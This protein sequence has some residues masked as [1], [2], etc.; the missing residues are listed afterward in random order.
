MAAQNED[1]DTLIRRLVESGYEEAFVR[2]L[3]HHD[4]AVRVR[5]GEQ[6]PT[7]ATHVIVDGEDG[8]LRLQRR[9]FSAF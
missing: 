7:S 4:Q 5:P 2:S 6:P 8:K 1:K 9:G 3:V